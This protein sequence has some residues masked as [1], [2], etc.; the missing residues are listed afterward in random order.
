MKAGV[1]IRIALGVAL[2]G[3]PA[4][5]AS[6]ESGQY[7]PLTVVVT[8]DAVSGTFFDGR[9]E[10][11]SSG[12]PPFTCIFRFK[13]RLDGVRAQIMTWA[14]GDA[15][16]IP[17]LLAFDGDAASLTLTRN[18]AGCD[19]AGDDMMRGPLTE[20]L[21]RRGAHWIGVGMVS[22]N[23]AALRP[24]PAASVRRTPYLIEF[25]PVV[26]LERKGGWVRAT[27]LGAESP[28]TGWLRQSDLAPDEPPRKAAWP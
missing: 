7:G 24:E 8:G 17:G 27:Y 12:V 10:P 14:P 25:D 20:P 21:F 13:G 18:Q 2:T 28:V 5:G 4:Y 15:T 3:L 22:V 6:V 9:G 16:S 11:G 26:I 1:G 23:R 19:T